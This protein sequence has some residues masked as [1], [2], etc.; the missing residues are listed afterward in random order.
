MLNHDRRNV[1]SGTRRL[2]KLKET[3]SAHKM[4]A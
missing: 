2:R 4:A 1:V 3:I